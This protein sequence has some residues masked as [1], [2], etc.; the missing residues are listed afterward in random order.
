[1]AGTNDFGRCADIWVAPHK[2]HLV[3][4]TEMPSKSCDRTRLTMPTRHLNLDDQE[5]PLLHQRLTS[6][7]SEQDPRVSYD[8]TQSINER[9]RITSET[10]S[11]ISRRVFTD[12]SGGSHIPNLSGF[13]AEYNRL[14]LKHEIPQFVE[15][16]SAVE[17]RK[18]LDGE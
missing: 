4:A 5:A 12:S 9:S 18:S 7:T 17:R 8:E 15:V 6:L 13:V 10:W 3:D 16:S 1:M 2:L 14:A 11:S